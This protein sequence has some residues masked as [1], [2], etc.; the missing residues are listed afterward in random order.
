MTTMAEEIEVAYREG[1]LCLPE[2]RV[3]LRRPRKVGTN[4]A[5]TVHTISM[6]L[7]LTWLFILLRNL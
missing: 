7:E 4:Q 5:S 2:F 6:T 3:P 1:H